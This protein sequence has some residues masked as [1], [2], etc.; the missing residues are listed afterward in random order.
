MVIS[1]AFSWYC[2]YEPCYHTLEVKTFKLISK[3]FSL[4]R[5]PIFSGICFFCSDFHCKSCLG[6]QFDENYKYKD[7]FSDMGI[8]YLTF[9]IHCVPCMKNMSLLCHCRSAVPRRFLWCCRCLFKLMPSQRYSFI[10]GTLRHF[11]MLEA[12]QLLANLACSI[13]RNIFFQI[14]AWQKN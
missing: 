8:S 10:S 14:A 4:F 11:Q 2:L 3:L 7:V 1:L 5:I 6:S 9:I 13:R 12:V